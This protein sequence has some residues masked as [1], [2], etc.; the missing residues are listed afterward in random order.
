MNNKNNKQNV[1]QIRAFDNFEFFK[2]SGVYTVPVKFPNN[3]VIIF[4]G[5]QSVYRLY[6]TH[7]YLQTEKTIRELEYDFTSYLDTVCELE[8]FNGNSYRDFINAITQLKIVC[9][10]IYEGT[11]EYIIPVK[12]HKK[13]EPERYLLYT[14]SDEQ[15]DSDREYY[16]ELTGCLGTLEDDCS[17]YGLWVFNSLEC[18]EN[19]N[20]A[21]ERLNGT[22]TED[23]QKDSL[24]VIIQK[25]LTI[26]TYYR[27]ID[28]VPSK[29]DCEWTETDFCWTDVPR[30][31]ICHC[32]REEDFQNI[33]DEK[34]RR[35]KKCTFDINDYY[36][37]GLLGIPVMITPDLIKMY[38]GCEWMLEVDIVFVNKQIEDGIAKNWTATEG[39]FHLKSDFIKEIPQVVVNSINTKVIQGLGGDLCS[40]IFTVLALVHD[41]IL[42]YISYEDY[43]QNIKKVIACRNNKKETANPV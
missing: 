9:V 12:L 35:L 37:L 28:K 18:P 40:E 27:Y 21:I 41:Y 10:R 39:G 26:D 24:F 5:E 30:N 36:S 14:M 43:D 33:Y 7:T 34:I 20:I 25:L 22:W 6:P 1:E 8:A 31:G 13:G 15:Y 11:Y 2:E 3:E 23:Y 4:T 42:P 29:L 38:F 32:M 17:E 19:N 16:M